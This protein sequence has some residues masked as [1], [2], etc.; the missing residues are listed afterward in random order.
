MLK[1]SLIT[2]KSNIYMATDKNEHLKKVLETNDISKVENFDRYVKKKNEVKEAMD[3]HYSI[4]RASKSIDSGSYAKKTANNT[5]FDIDVCTPFK[6]KMK[7]D[8]NGFFTLK[9]MFDDV[10]KYLRDEYSEDDNDLK[11]ENV[12]KQKVSIGLKFIFDDG[13]E[14]ELDVVPGR[15]RPNNGSYN[16][17]STDLTL[18]INPTKRTKKEIED[19]KSSIKTNVKKHVSLLSGSG[20]THERKVARLLK[21]WKTEKKEKDG[22]KLI[23]SF[24]MEL[25]TKEAFDNAESIPNG[26]W[27]KA[28]MVMEYIIDNIESKNLVDPANT[29]NIVSDSMSD[30]A[31]TDTRK[32]MQTTIDEIDENSDKIKEHFPINEE[33]DTSDDDDNKSSART[34]ATVLGTNKFG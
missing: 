2:L 32:S 24:M 34:S 33:Y 7:E 27:K 4:E 19:T 18:Y 8:D 26:L 1:V 31:K 29:G 10:Y 30:S 25:Y 28:K 15:E 17:D 6:N 23:K 22:G 21:V 20:R 16:D 14:L 9:D 11:K 13:D 5:K 3:S 12:R